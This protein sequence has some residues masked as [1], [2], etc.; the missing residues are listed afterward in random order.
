MDETTKKRERKDGYVGEQTK[1]FI[2]IVV[3]VG[4]IETHHFVLA[5]LVL[6]CTNVVSLKM[7]IVKRSTDCV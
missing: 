1:C 3:V 7:I 5:V 4:S 2:F 6:Q